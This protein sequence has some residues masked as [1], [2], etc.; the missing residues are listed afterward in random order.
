[1]LERDIFVGDF[2][3]AGGVTATAIR[4]VGGRG[5]AFDVI[6]AR[7]CCAT[8]ACGSAFGT[9]TEHAE[10][11]GDNFEAGALLA[12]FILPFAGLDAPFDE[13]QRTLLKILL[14]NFDLLAPDNDFVPL[15]AR[16]V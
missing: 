6:A 10:V 9:A 12:F 5:V 14:S 1:M 11:V 8:G 2:R 15:G 4:I 3:A 7:A 13:D 16:L